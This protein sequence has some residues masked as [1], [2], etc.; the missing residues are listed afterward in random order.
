ML[1]GCQ[2]AIAD[3]VDVFNVFNVFNTK[4]NTNLMD[5]LYKKS[6]TLL[7]FRLSSNKPHSNAIKNLYNNFFNKNVT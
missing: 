7:N 2:M 1:I 3:V 6:L 4:L 5:F